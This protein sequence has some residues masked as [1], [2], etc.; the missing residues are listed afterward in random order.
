MKPLKFDYICSACAKKRG[1]TWPKGHMATCHMDNCP[2]CKVR[3]GLCNIGDWNWPDK[4]KRG[5]RD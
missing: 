5:M 4:V 3:S 1:A 2:Y